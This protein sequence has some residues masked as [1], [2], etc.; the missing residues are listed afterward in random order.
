MILLNNTQNYD[1]NQDLINLLKNQ[2]KHFQTKKL[3]IKCPTDFTQSLKPYYNAFANDHIE[4]ER[5]LEI[6]NFEIDDETLSNLLKSY[7]DTDTI[8]F[9]NARFSSLE[10]FSIK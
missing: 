7:A 10:K 9:I 4:V 1:Y 2:Y 8:C 6:H 3:C 5:T